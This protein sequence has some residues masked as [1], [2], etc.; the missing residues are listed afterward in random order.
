MTSYVFKRK[1]RALR[2]TRKI[3]L[4]I[5]HPGFADIADNVIDKAERGR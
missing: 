1:T 4:F 3:Y 5:S 2:K